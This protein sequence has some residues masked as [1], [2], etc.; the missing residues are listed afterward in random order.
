MPGGSQ[1]FDVRKSISV[2]TLALLNLYPQALRVV[3]MRI[4]VTADP[5]TTNNTTWVLPT[6]LFTWQR[7]SDYINTRNAANTLYKTFP[8]TPHNGVTAGNDLVVSSAEIENG[9][10]VTIEFIWAGID[11]NTNTGVGGIFITTWTKLADTLQKVAD[12]TLVNHNDI[13][14]T[15][16]VSSADN[17]GSIG[18]LVQL[19]SATG[20]FSYSGYVRALFRKAT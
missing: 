8:I 1:S 20:N 15:I 13:G 10:S 7:E 14:G 16:T 11:D 17:S 5:D 18:I 6:D 12:T 9:E 4:T 3:G 19:V 2:E